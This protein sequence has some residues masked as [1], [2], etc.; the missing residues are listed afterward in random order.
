MSIRGVAR[1]LY[2]TMM[3]V[4]ELKSKLRDRNIPEA[5]KTELAEQL[6]QTMAERDRVQAMLEGAKDR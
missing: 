2:R 4:E 5:E 1:E 6:R 3:R